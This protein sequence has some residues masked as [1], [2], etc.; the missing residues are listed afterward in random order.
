MQCP[1]CLLGRK[2]NVLAS[3]SRPSLALHP[4]SSWLARRPGRAH[5]P[6][7]VDVAIPDPRLYPV[8]L[9]PRIDVIRFR[10]PQPCVQ[11]QSFRRCFQ[12]CFGVLFISL[13]Q[14]PLQHSRA[15]TLAL[16]FGICGN[17]F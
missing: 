2:R 11:R 8:I 13:L 6:Y 5:W 15:G 4:Y 12:I 17:H 16:V 3:A 10:K 1:V 9:N 7:H 14:S